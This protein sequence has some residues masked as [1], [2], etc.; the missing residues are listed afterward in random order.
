MANAPMS[1]SVTFNPT[2]ATKVPE[3]QFRV[4]VGCTVLTFTLSTQGSEEPALFE[5]PPL[6]WHDPEA[7]RKAFGEPK[8]AADQLSFTVQDSNQNSGKDPDHYGFSFSILH[9]G[10]TYRPDPAIINDPPGS[11]SPA[12]R[13]LFQWLQQRLEAWLPA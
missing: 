4:P 2:T 9:G 6:L 3:R 12:W 10:Q 13:R 11:G 8:V 7:A 5:S 1:F